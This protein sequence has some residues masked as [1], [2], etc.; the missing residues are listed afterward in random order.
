MLD[1]LISMDVPWE[2][3]EVW[4]V[5]ERVAPDGHEARN[6]NQLHELSTVAK[7]HLMAVAALDLRAAARRYSA[8]L[9]DRFD[10]VH[11]G[12]GADGHMASWPPGDVTVRE[13]PRSVEVVESFNGWPRL[14]LT[15]RVVNRARSRVVLTSGDTKRPMVERWLLA[16]PT[17]P[18]TALRR[19]DTWVFVDQA[20]APGVAIL[21]PVDAEFDLPT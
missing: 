3:V 15:S 11:L 8:S 6:A 7:V 1:A 2:R 16:D 5:D 19:T 13:S 18:A 14:T 20:A 4:Q 9:P 10:I 17:I 21:H 12:L